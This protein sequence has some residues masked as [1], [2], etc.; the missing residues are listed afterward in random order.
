MTLTAQQ[1]RYQVEKKL[2]ADPQLLKQA[3]AATPIYPKLSAHDGHR[4]T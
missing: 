1:H 2:T 3:P 4:Y